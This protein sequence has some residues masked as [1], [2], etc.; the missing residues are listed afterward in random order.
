[1]EGFKECDDDLLMNQVR[2]CFSC[3]EI[4][5]N[6]LGFVALKAEHLQDFQV[7]DSQNYLDAAMTPQEL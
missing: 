1:M 4:C 3:L 2:V 5:V 6:F 7:T